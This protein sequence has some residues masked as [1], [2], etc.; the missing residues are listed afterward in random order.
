MD[1]IL[2]SQPPLLNT[3]PF[4]A[5]ISVMTSIMICKQE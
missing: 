5:L 3:A 1:L 2:D 4:S